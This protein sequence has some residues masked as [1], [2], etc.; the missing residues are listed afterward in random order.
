MSRNNSQSLVTGFELDFWGSILNKDWDLFLSHHVET[1]LGAHETFHSV[2]TG[3]F[4]AGKVV[5]DVKLNAQ[6]SPVQMFKIHGAVL[7]LRH[8]LS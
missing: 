7:A 8:T 4:W 6:L 1:G 3:N 2:R 5:G